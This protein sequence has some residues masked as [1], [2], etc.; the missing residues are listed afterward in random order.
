MEFII[1]TGDRADNGRLCLEVTMLIDRNI[2]IG[3]SGD[4]LG[5]M[6]LI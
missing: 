1:M 6:M 3:I 2:I 5:F 4:I